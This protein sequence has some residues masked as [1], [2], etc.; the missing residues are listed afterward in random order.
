MRQFKLFIILSLLLSFITGQLQLLVNN[1]IYTKTKIPAWQKDAV[2]YC[3]N[4]IIFKG[5]RNHADDNQNML[6]ESYSPINRDR[7]ELKTAY[8]FVLTNVGNDPRDFEL[9]N[10]EL[11]FT[12]G[13]IHWSQSSV[14]I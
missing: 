1:I 3:L 8:Y 9:P 2:V 7:Y 12:H 13:A 14:A 5:H 4:K 10:P 11:A 6:A